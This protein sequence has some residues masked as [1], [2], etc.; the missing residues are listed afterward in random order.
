MILATE[1]PAPVNTAMEEFLL[2]RMSYTEYPTCEG[3]EIHCARESNI[4]SSPKNFDKRGNESRGMK[5]NGR[6]PHVE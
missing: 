1:H 5:D 4:N 6:C 3:H 2:G